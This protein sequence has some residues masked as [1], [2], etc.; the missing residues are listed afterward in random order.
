MYRAMSERL[1][2]SVDRSLSAHE[3][4]CRPR[5]ADCAVSGVTTGGGVGR[6]ARESGSNVREKRDCVCNFRGT[7]RS[8]TGSADSRGQKER[9]HRPN[10]LAAIQHPS[11]PAPSPAWCL[12][13]RLV[14]TASV[15]EERQP[16]LYLAGHRLVD[17]QSAARP[18][19]LTVSARDGLHV[20]DG[21][22]ELERREGGGAIRL[23]TSSLV[24]KRLQKAQG[25]GEGERER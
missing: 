21:G 17:R 4:R 14:L 6:Q 9:A 25:E 23:E 5:V 15:P 3:E 12:P 13:D 2:P 8:R 18:Q 10:Q 19:R 20:A 22:V 1:F 24:R 7:E 16:E 11:T